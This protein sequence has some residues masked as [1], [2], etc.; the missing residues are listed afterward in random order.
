MK[1][2]GLLLI[3]C[4]IAL[5]FTVSV[6]AQDA[7]I[8]TWKTNNPGSPSGTIKIPMLGGPFTIDWGDG[9]IE[10]NQYN[11]V[12]H[13]YSSTSVYTVIISGT[14]NRI[15]FNNGIGGNGIDRRKL[16]DIEQWGTNQWTS[17]EGAFHGCSNLTTIS[18]TDSPDL[19]DIEYFDGYAPEDSP[20]DP[21]DIYTLP[22]TMKTINMFAGATN[23]NGAI[24]HWDMSNVVNMTSMFEEATYFNQ[25]IGN[26]NVRH[27]RIFKAM[28]R[29]ATSFNQDISSWSVSGP[30]PTF[31][32]Y[33]NVDMSYM[34]SGA[35][36]FDRNLGNWDVSNVINAGLIEGMT[37]MF[38]GVTLSTANYDSILMGWNSQNLLPNVVFNGGNSHYCNAETDRA[39]MMSSDNWDIDDAG[40]EPPNTTAVDD[41]N[42]ELNDSD[43][44]GTL[45]AI[46]IN[47]TTDFC[48]S[49][50]T[51]K[52]S[53]NI[54]GTFYNNVDSIDFDSANLGESYTITLTVTT[55][56]GAHNTD[57]VNVTILPA[58]PVIRLASLLTPGE[59]TEECVL[60][61][62][63]DANKPK[64]E[65][66]CDGPVIIG[67]ASP[68]FPIYNST[69]ITWT[70]TD[71][72]GASI[73]TTQEVTITNAAHADY[74]YIDNDDC[75]ETTVQLD[76][77]DDKDGSWS[78]S[79]P[80]GGAYSFSEITD[81]DS[82]FT[83]E[84]G[85]RYDITWT[86][87]EGETAC[88]E[89]QTATIT[90]EFPACGDFIDFN[91][92]DNSI[93]FGD[94]Y[95]LSGDFSIEV[96]IKPEVENSHIQTILS[97]RDSTSTSTMNTGYDLRLVDG[98][99]SFNVNSSIS[100][101]TNDNSIEDDR[102]YH[103]A[104]TY[105]D[106][107]YT[108][109]V[110]G[111]FID[112]TTSGVAPTPNDSD[113]RLGAMARSTNLPTNY[114][115]GWL[116]ELRIWDVALSTDQIRMMMNQEI[117]ENSGNVIG[118]ITGS[119]MN[120][121]L[122]WSNLKGYYQMNQE[123]DINDGYLN[124]NKG[125]DGRLVSMTSLQS[126]TAPLPYVTATNGNWDA[127]STW[128]NSSDQM[129]PNADGSDINWNIVKIKHNVTSG[130]RETKLLGLLID[131]GKEFS[132]T[133]DNPLSVSRY[134]KID[135][136]LDLEG[137][138]QLIQSEGSIVDYTGRG[139][140]ERDQQGTSNKYNYNYWGSPVSYEGTKYTIVRALSDG[141]NPLNPQ[142]IN[143]INGH[144]GSATTPISLT[145]RWLYLY[146]NYLIDS[147]AAWNDINENS[148]IAVGLGFTMKGSGTTDPN[149]NYVFI[150]QPNNG[151]I[152]T[153]VSGGNQALVGNPYPSAIDAHTFIDNN[154]DVMEDGSIAIWQHA[155]SNSSHVLSE[156]EGGYAYR[157]KTEGI[158]AASL[159]GINGTGNANTVPGQY[160]PVAQGFYVT[161]NAS[162]GNIIFNNNQRVFKKEGSSSSIFLRN[163]T[164]SQM[165][166]T[167]DDNEE[168]NQYI[169]LDFLTPENATRHLLL[170]FMDNENATDGIDYGYDALNIETFP[171]DMS[172]NI[173]GEKFLIQGVGEFDITKTYP[174]DMVLGEQGNIEIGLTAL[175][176]F[177]TTIDVF[178]YDALEGSYTQFNDVNFQMNLEA[179]N[180]R[181]RFYIAFQ[182]DE[183]L[184]TIEDEF[185]HVSVMFLNQSSEIYV[186]TPPT[187]QVKQLYLINLL[188]QTIASWNATN[189][190]M[191]NTI[192]IPVK[193][194]S[195]GAYILKAETDTGVFNR[196]IIINYN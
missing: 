109:Y 190:P 91:G 1:K 110:D 119:L 135:G 136:T 106:T 75:T 181:E 113:M 47:N 161:G 88:P 20:E 27:V 69:T 37:G 48:G 99:I 8:T 41:F 61:E 5:T 124:P 117:Q 134:L 144:D 157:N 120:T 182:E 29:E 85:E 137:E 153:P 191:S 174:L 79:S 28:F 32:A 34:F 177:D 45:S 63:T 83:G 168:N 185:K 173:D 170:G 49:I 187:I 195:E 76:A 178:I 189:L 156:Y 19:G 151:D 7:F 139:Q 66:S 26:W 146:E 159:D 155:D 42:F 25:D 141:T 65:S 194:I 147:Y 176:N 13:T 165:S 94:N 160:I 23:F 89:G 67:V 15:F 46:A 196:K 77:N 40:L 164:N 55:T 22:A 11:L 58:S 145:R 107:T 140:L 68:S 100:V 152:T 97:K 192:V 57:T 149:Q 80:T 102:W 131:S 43:C 129:L 103:I 193:N 128:L 175:E 143:W 54:E 162:G 86:L 133:D 21:N 104:V 111:V 127:P 169:R 87:A 10:T 4:L 98:D 123:S 81:F 158:A 62:P 36:A 105:D 121:D 184:S 179:G 6:F 64:A 93:N 44:E 14:Y 148:T 116:D 72:Y 18:A 52:M 125:V 16:I 118:S 35:I 59:L 112:S 51:I 132:I 114:Y 150:G 74:T 24:G 166:S 60:Y 30:T 163:N 33:D 126:E 142:Q 9:S 71:A 167:T 171:S 90:V 115:N 56:N 38:E 188:G 78:A 17:M 180:Y 154:I 183:T 12:E 101:S 82:T 2:S 186:Q 73:S 96:W 122:S 108:L 138:S 50:S 130:D 31:P 39:N 70:F 95:D 84:S 3:Q 172:F 53:A 92:T